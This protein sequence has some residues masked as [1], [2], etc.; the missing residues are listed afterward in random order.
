VT[1]GVPQGSVLGLVLF[2]IFI[3]DIARSS[4]PSSKFADDTKPSGAV[5]TTKGRD[6]I[7]RDLDKMERWACVNLKRFSKTRCKVLHLDRG[8]PQYQYRLR[9]GGIESPAEKNLWVLMEEKLN[10]S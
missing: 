1:S 8:N 2:I 3:N 4:A 6:A 10:V 5:D 7:L 9:K